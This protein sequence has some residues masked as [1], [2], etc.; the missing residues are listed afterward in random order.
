MRLGNAGI[1][2]EGLGEMGKLRMTWLF[3]FPGVSEWWRAKDRDPMPTG[4][5]EEIDE[6]IVSR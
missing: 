6:F 1:L 3:T 5:G 4:F 2:S